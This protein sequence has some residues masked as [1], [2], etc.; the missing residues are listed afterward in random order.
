[1]GLGIA[2]GSQTL[3]LCRPALRGGGQEGL[4]LPAL[5]LG[6]LRTAH[7]LPCAQLWGPHAGHPVR[8]NLGAGART[9]CSRAEGGL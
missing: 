8:G 9:R 5:C 4:G 6:G 3:G 1:M 7:H 2:R